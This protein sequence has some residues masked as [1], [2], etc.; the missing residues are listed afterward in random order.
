MFEPVSVV[1]ATTVVTHE[2]GQTPKRSLDRTRSVDS[3]L[4]EFRISTDPPHT[5]TTKLFGTN[6]KIC[7]KIKKAYAMDV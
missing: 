3:E 7:P 5:S 2:L 4:S 1:L 6:P